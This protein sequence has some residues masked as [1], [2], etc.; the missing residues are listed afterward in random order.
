[1]SADRVAGH[2]HRL[3]GVPA[4]ASYFN[5]GVLLLDLPECRRCGV[6]DAAVAYLSAHPRSPY[7]DQDA[8]NAAFDGLWLPIDAR[9]NFQNHHVT[10]VDR[11]P[12][13]ERPSIVHFITGS[14]PWKPS[15]ASV[16]AALYDRYRR[17]TL[18]RRTPVERMVATVAS[19]GWRARY[20]LGRLGAIL[21]KADLVQPSRDPQARVES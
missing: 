20:R 2:S 5:A 8:L 15:S 4:V 14:K 17:R 13:P 19:I 21:P 7:A 18:Y 11:M 12:A 16:N 10:R 6:F 1:V 3:V 9:W